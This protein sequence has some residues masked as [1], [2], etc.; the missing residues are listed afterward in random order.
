MK[1]EKILVSHSIK[2][3]MKNDL[4]IEVGTEDLPFNKINDVCEQIHNYMSANFLN[5]GFKFDNSNFYYTYQRLCFYFEQIDILIEVPELMIRG[6]KVE[7]VSGVINYETNQVIGFAKKNKVSVDDLIVKEFSGSE[8][9]FFIQP[10]SSKKLEDVLTETI[11][12]SFSKVQSHKLMKWGREKHYFLRPI[13]WVLILLDHHFVRTKIFNVESSKNSFLAKVSGKVEVLNPQDYFEKLKNKKV[14]VK[15]IERR[16]Y[17]SK[18]INKLINE[19]FDID[20]LE[21]AIENFSNYSETPYLFQGSYPKEYLNLPDEIIIEVIYKTQN[22]IP[23]KKDGKLINY[24]IG[25]SEVPINNS[26]ISGNE[27]VI[28]PKFKDVS[29]F[30]KKDVS[31]QLYNKIE[32]LNNITFHKKIGSVGQKILRLAALEKSF[33]CDNNYNKDLL[34]KAIQLLKFDLLSQ[35]VNEMPSLEGYFANYLIQN[36]NIDKNVGQIIEDHYAPRTAID[37]CP[38]TIEGSIASIL[39]KCDTIFSIFSVNEVPTGTRD[40]F[41]IRRL[42]NGVIRTAIDKKINFC[43]KDLLKNN[44]VLLGIK[45]SE[46][47]LQNKVLIF[48]KEKLKTLIIEYYKADENIVNMVLSKSSEHSFDICDIYNRTVA[49]ELFMQKNSIEDIMRISKRIHNIL[50]NTKE[51]QDKINDSLFKENSEEILYTSFNKLN[52]VINP[53]SGRDKYFNYLEKLNILN[54]DVDNFFENVMINDSDEKIKS[55][56]LC[57]LKNLKKFYSQIAD[58]SFVTKN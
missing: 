45:E 15:N 8:Y 14:L 9:F 22:L 48:F 41:G 54:S 10:K 53:N 3:N 50:K 29:F 42:T 5:N 4:L 52:E 49:I 28:I 30:I 43:L 46:G 36:S 26:I 40:P 55:N 27:K 20:N 39:D 19:K 17:I 13:R 32:E 21:D 16:E 56:R 24:F 2:K 34:A 6:P 38:L 1:L 35:T 12:G 57:F 18:E 25:L 44:A 51:N 58:F 31:D 7:K 11:E 37:N 23:L 47:N 33:V